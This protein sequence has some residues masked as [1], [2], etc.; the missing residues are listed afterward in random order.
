MTQSK[1]IHTNGFA[2]NFYSSWEWIRCRRDFANSRSHLCERCLAKGLITIGTEV[3][4]KIRLTPENILNPEVAL[5]WDNL[6]LLCRDCHQ[7]EHRHAERR[8]SGMSDADGHI[9]L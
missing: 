6:E 5:N 2:H 9:S 4:H 8:W 3:H 7:A 1:P